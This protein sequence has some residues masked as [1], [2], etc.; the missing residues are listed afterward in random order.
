MG[1]FPNKR[2]LLEHAQPGLAR[3][4][5]SPSAT[6]AP[7]AP[8][9]TRDQPGSRAATVALSQRAGH[10]RVKCH[11]ATVPAPPPLP[12]RRSEDATKLDLSRVAGISPRLPATLT[13]A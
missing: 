4:D 7:A 13:T 3:L 9:V 2:A 1:A 11:I 10:I 5:P 6:P 8:P 12:G